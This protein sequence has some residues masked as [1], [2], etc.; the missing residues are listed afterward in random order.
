MFCVNS[1]PL[2]PSPKLLVNLTL[3]LNFSLGI[4]IPEPES[5]SK[6]TPNLLLVLTIF[7]AIF[8]SPKPYN[9]NNC[10]W[11]NVTTYLS[12]QYQKN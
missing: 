8:I 7:S 1:S 5:E 9:Q 4:K 3:N 12:N 11:L 2:A 10:I 6:G